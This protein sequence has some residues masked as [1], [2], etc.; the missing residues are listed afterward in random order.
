MSNLNLLQQE[1]ATLK[2]KYPELVGWR[3]EIDRRASRRAG[4]CKYGPRIIGISLW[5]VQ[6]SDWEV[7]QDT[8]RHEVA[9]VLAGP[10]ARHGHLWQ[11]QA[12]RV[13]A[14]PRA[15]FSSADP[16]FNKPA[17]WRT[18]CPK[19]GDIGG[20]NRRPKYHNIPG[21]RICKRCK[22]PVTYQYSSTGKAIQTPVVVPISAPVPVPMAASRP[23]PRPTA[24]GK[25]YIYACIV[26][27]EVKASNNIGSR[28]RGMGIA[29]LLRRL[30]FPM[31][32]DQARLWLATH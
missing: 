30:P 23:A 24:G 1:W 32:K 10:F 28:E 19:C 16:R 14:T 18:I 22:S 4:V 26:R 20:R 21:Y 25:T 13:G 17:P 11:A 3:M 6:H 27:G 5:H 7:V 8:L 29:N 9:H 12:I 31:T 15:C 2:A